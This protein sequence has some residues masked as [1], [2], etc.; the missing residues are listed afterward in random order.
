MSVYQITAVHGRDSRKPPILPFRSPAGLR[1][2]HG[3]MVNYLYAPDEIEK[4]HEALAEK[5]VIAAS[6]AV[7]KAHP[8]DASASGAA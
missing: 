1:Q 8:G 4:N 5:G 7:R 3:L 6:P 2:A